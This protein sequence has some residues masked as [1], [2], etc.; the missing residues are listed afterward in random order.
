MCIISFPPSPRREHVAYNVEIPVPST[1]DSHSVRYI[2]DGRVE[3]PVEPCEQKP[4]QGLVAQVDRVLMPAK[5]CQ[6]TEHTPETCNCGSCGQCGQK[7]ESCS[8]GSSCG[9][10]QTPCS[11]GNDGYNLPINY[12]SRYEMKSDDS[13]N[14]PAFT[15]PDSMNL[16]R[17]YEITLSRQKRSAAANADRKRKSKRRDITFPKLKPLKKISPKSIKPLEPIFKRSKK[18]KTESRQSRP[19]RGPKS[20]CGYTYESCDPKKHSRNGCPLCYKCKCEPVNKDPENARFSPRDIKIP[21][22][23][24]THNESPGS[25]AA[26]QEF[27]HEPSS[28]TGLRDQQMYQKYI[29]QIISKYPEH[30]SRKMPD[31]QDQQKDLMKFIGEL[32]T[33]NKSPGAKV[34]GED[35]RYK[36]MDNA[37]DMYKYYEKA[38]SGLPKGS[39][40]TKDGKLFKKRGTVL[41]VIELDSED[42]NGSALGVPVDELGDNYSASQ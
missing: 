12:N 23:V 4:C 9:C 33:S 39:T 34:E 10:G 6:N 42:Y 16:P 7:Q 28:Y 32:A 38:L 13:Q 14:F 17:A 19:K 25:A 21:Y 37:M 8:C 2:F 20:P 18:L 26:N 30:M 27:D 5:G 36:M 41:E 15:F 31:I 3:K 35:I 1:P 40:L 11:C 24:V 22:K 29:G